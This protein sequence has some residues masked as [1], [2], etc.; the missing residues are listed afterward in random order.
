MAFE[1]TAS[2]DA[3]CVAIL[4][5]FEETATTTNS[6]DY[7]FDVC[8]IGHTNEQVIM[9]RLMFSRTAKT[10]NGNDNLVHV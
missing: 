7:F 1:S 6:Y 8:E 4:L 2:V 10:A 9:V 5:T 3:R